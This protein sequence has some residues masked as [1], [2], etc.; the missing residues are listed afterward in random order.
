[1]LIRK[2]LTADEFSSPYLR[3]N[4][5]CD[6][7]QFTP[8]GGETWVDQPVND[9]RSSDAYRLPP[10]TGDDTQCRAAE[11]MTQ[12]VRQAVNARLATENQIQ[13]AG[14]ILGIVSLIPGFGVLW[15]LILALAAFALTIAQEVLEA[16]FTDGVYDQIRCIFYCH[17]D[18]DGQMSATQFGVCYAA[19]IDL[20]TIPRTWVQNVMN[21]FGAVGMTNAGVSLQAAADCECDCG[22]C[23]QDDLTSTDDSFASTG[24]FGTYTSGQGWTNTYADGGGQ[25]YNGLQI[26]KDFGSPLALTYLNIQ[27][28]HNSTSANYPNTGAIDALD[29]WNGST[30]VNVATLSTVFYA[31]S[32][33]DPVSIGGDVAVTASKIRVTLY[34]GLSVGG[35]ASNP[36][37]NCRFFQLTFAG[38]GTPPFGDS[39]CP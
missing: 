16:A 39:T 12:L 22:W 36:G 3:Y 4:A 24:F 35:D 38:T 10:L 19:L 30:W 34:A 25:G 37:G 15:A 14:A 2:K 8:D 7:V 23:Y 17:I 1:M 27:Y 28:Y 31:A 11:G 33:I 13:L 21:T 5:D 20:D 29:Y 32:L 26:V 9:P 18:I 6:C